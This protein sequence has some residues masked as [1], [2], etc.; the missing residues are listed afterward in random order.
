[1][2]KTFLTVLSLAFFLASLLAGCGPSSSHST[3]YDPGHRHAEEV[4]EIKLPNGP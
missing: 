2:P 1:M 3:G 4:G